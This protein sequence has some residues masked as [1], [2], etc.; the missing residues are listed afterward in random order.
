MTKLFSGVLLPPA[1]RS[2]LGHFS[3][4]SPVVELAKEI[5]ERRRPSREQ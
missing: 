1:H 4:G 2:V 3:T 5:V